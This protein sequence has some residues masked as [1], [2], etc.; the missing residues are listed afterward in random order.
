M[1]EY[2]LFTDS[3][4]DL[5]ADLVQQLDL[6]VIPMLFEMDGKSY[7]N[8][9]DNH[10][11][12]PK[13][14]YAALRGGKVCTTSQVSPSRFDEIFSPVLES[15]RDILYLCFSSGLSGT[16]NTSRL[17]VEELR[18]KF[19]DRKIRTVDTLAASMGQGLLV[20]LAAKKRQEGMGLDELGDWVEENRLK[21]CHWFTVDDLMFLKR[22]GRVSG[23]A[24]VMGT[25][26]GIKPVLHV[27]DEGHLIPMEKVRGRRASLDALVKHM[28]A[29]AIRPAEQT[30]F[31]SHG[32]C[33]AD[34]DYVAQ[35]LREK[36][37]VKEIVTSYIGPVIG[38][39]SGP[40]TVAL[41]FVGEKR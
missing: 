31:I 34:C 3:N 39:H 16:Y 8:Y 41:F 38:A 17:A 9:P 11:M 21:L 10:E 32:D 29:T 12:D 5:P 23:A 35:Q 1:S 24:A 18:E 4:T 28:Q 37:G 40:G 6:S 2:V 7:Y 22:G 14:F 30:V 25:M 19:P 20:Y 33:Q 13:E 15:G 27:D 26:L 36:L